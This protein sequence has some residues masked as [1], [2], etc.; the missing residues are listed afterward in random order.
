[1]VTVVTCV[2]QSLNVGPHGPIKSSSPWTSWV[3]AE[4]VVL[5][6][7]ENTSAGSSGGDKKLFYCNGITGIK[8]QYLG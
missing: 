3:G 8:P 5:K 6:Y 1:M 7:T 2:D 4:E